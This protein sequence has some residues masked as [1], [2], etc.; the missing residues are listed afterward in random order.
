MTKVEFC[1][2]LSGLTAIGRTMESGRRGFGS[3]SGRKKLFYFLAW[4]LHG[5]ARTVLP[6]SDQCL[7]H[8]GGHKVLTLAIVFFNRQPTGPQLQGSFLELLGQK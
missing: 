7:G 4:S 5:N 1:I 8:H 6:S 3:S 2:L